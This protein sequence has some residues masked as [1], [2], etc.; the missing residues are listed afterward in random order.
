MMVN[1]ATFCFIASWWATALAD[2]S[3]ITL[4]QSTLGGKCLDGTQAG[5]Y[6]EE[7]TQTSLYVIA[8]EGG[9]YCNTEGLAKKRVGT[10]L[11]GSNKWPSKKDGSEQDS[12]F[13][14]TD[15]DTN[16]DFCQANRVLIPYCTG[17]T[18]LGRRHEDLHESFGMYFDGRLNFE[19]IVN[20]LIADHGMGNAAN[21]LLTGTS[22]GGIG[23]FHNVD[24]L[25]EHVPNANVKAIPVAGWFFP[26]S[27]EKGKSDKS[28]YVPPSDY[29]H[30]AAGTQG[31]DMVD[32]Y[33]TD[34]DP[35]WQVE[36]HPI[37]AINE[38]DH[39]EFCSVLDVVYKY[40][41]SPVFAVQSQFD[42]HHI[43]DDFN[44]PFMS[45]GSTVE[46]YI[47]MYGEASRKSLQQII[48]GKSLVPKSHP[49]GLYSSSCLSHGNPP[50][51]RVDDMDYITLAHDWFFQINQ[52]ESQHQ[53]VETCP[54]GDITLPC[55]P[56]FHCQYKPFTDLIYY[57]PKSIWFLFSVILIFWAYKWNQNRKRRDFDAQ[58]HDDLKFDVDR[59]KLVL[60]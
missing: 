30:F 10:D 35:L 60:T 21:I 31:N 55:N 48:D 40:I 22:A 25:A 43:Y 51:I 37:C 15:C 17:D 45:I 58:N 41:E 57:I 8:L 6:F 54:G 44:T 3:L 32:S 46:D 28:D 9:G 59:K 33:T 4:P 26:R 53:L 47:T 50:E 36:P 24:W 49:D 16:P 1:K 20:K 38:K 7:G 39:P 12:A 34:S 11:G 27:V 14:D 52:Y 23:T 5:Y 18:H 19:A 29:P 2:M 56:H 13:L 42:S